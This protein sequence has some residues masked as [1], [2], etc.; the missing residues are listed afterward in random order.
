MVSTTP[1]DKNCPSSQFPRTISKKREPWDSN[2]E[3]ATVGAPQTTSTTSSS[4]SGSLLPRIFTQQQVVPEIHPDPL[5]PSPR[6]LSL[7]GHMEVDGNGKISS[8]RTYNWLSICLKQS[9]L[10]QDH[11]FLRHSIE[12]QDLTIN[13]WIYMPY[14]LTTYSF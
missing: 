13:W 9:D 3:I 1:S 7:Q 14:A 5:R 11:T 4:M 6:Q 2:P 8:G 12:Y 10:R